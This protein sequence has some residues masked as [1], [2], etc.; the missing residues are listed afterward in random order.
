VTPPLEIDRRTFLK[1]LGEGVVVVASL[2]PAELLAQERRPSY[3]TDFNLYVRIG[4][5]GKVTVF[6]GKI[7]MGQ[8][9]LTSQ[10][11]MA[12]DE[13]G[14]SLRAVDMVLGD[15]ARCRG[16][17]G[18]SD[19][20]P[21]GCSARSSAPPAPRH[22]GD[23]P[24]GLR[25]P[26]GPERG[27]G[28]RGRRRRRRGRPAAEG[29]L[30]GA[31]EG[32]GD[33][34]HGGREG[35]PALDLRVP[36]DGPVLPAPRRGGEGDRPREVHRRHPPSRNA[37]RADPASAAHG[38]TLEAVDTTAAAAIRRGYRG[39]EG[40]P[41][42]RAARR[43][44]GGGPGAGRAEAHL[45]RRALGADQDGIFDDLQRRATE[46]QVKESRGEI[47][48]VPASSR[49]FGPPIEKATWR[50]RRWSRTRHWPR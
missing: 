40:R 12:A 15:T 18:R 39:P 37:P 35:G 25:A 14:V 17:W 9:V 34:P 7:E 28:G 1:Y 45:A 27:S 47:S 24:A 10:A 21:C 41:G 30:R 5:D 42:G 50:T 22:A 36:R 16:T 38:S 3:P 13:L 8:G 11:Q 29:L 19:R 6:S 4:E 49:L 44:G 26:G 23:G 31:G 43:P 20:S 32:Q 48:D 46:A 33:P 2:G